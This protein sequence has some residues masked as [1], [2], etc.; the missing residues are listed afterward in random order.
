[1]LG[2]TVC[3]SKDSLEMLQ[4]FKSTQKFIFKNWNNTIRCFPDYYHGSNLH[5]FITLKIEISRNPSLQRHLSWLKSSLVL[6]SWKYPQI[7]VSTVSIPYYFKFPLAKSTQ[8]KV[9]TNLTDNSRLTGQLSWFISSQIH[10]IKVR[11]FHSFKSSQVSHCTSSNLY[12]QKSTQ[13]RI[14]SQL[15]LKPI[16]ITDYTEQSLHRL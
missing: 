13:A 7:Q 15:R 6:L 2:C 16:Q 4:R 12:R 14:N 9:Y 11:Y 8:S 5:K 10:V 1:M 3:Q